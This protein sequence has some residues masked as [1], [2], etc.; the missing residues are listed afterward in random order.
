MDCAVLL[1]FEACNVLHAG[2]VDL[3]R[4]VEYLHHTLQVGRLLGD[5]F[6][7]INRILGNSCRNGFAGFSCKVGRRV[8]GIK[9]NV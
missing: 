6:V 9:P 2:G 7:V 8:R 1:D 3:M 5:L 4:P